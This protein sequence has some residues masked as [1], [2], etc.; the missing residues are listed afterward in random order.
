[1]YHLSTQPENRPVLQ[2]V[3][4]FVTQTRGA[5]VNRRGRLGLGQLLAQP[6]LLSLAP[7]HLALGLLHLA[8]G[9]GR[10]PSGVFELPLEAGLVGHELAGVLM[11]YRV[12]STLEL[13]FTNI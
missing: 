12:Y 4:H 1:M 6:D 2:N 8:P 3:W 9:I 7:L 11:F 10:Q 13:G 5:Y